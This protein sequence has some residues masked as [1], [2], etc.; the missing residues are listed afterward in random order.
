MSLAESPTWEIHDSTKLQA[1]SR[2]P[3]AYLFEY[4]LGWRPEQPNIHLEFGEAWHRAMET[5]LIHGYSVE[6]QE[7][8]YIR[9]RQHYR[10]FFSEMT[11]DIYYP[12][13][14]GFAKDML[15][16]YCSKYKDDFYHWKVVY[17]EIS[18]RVSI[19]ALRSLAFKV[20]AVVQLT[21][22]P[23]VGKYASPEHKT[24]K[25]MKGAWTR[26]WTNKVQI[27]TYYHVLKCL[28]GSDAYG[29]I[30][31]GAQFQKTDPNFLRLHMI[32][33]IAQMAQWQWEVV[34][35][36]Q[37]IEKDL[38]ICLNWDADKPFLFAFPRNGEACTDYNHPCQYLEYCSVW[39]NPLRF[40][41]NPPQG[42]IVN[43]WNPL[44]RETTHNIDI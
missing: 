26:Q 3:R 7:L 30:I 41:D 22:G 20:D 33:S 37:E 18:G 31:N 4:V 21:D 12:K 24:T 6:A 15:K 1:H 38:E 43:H 13:T 17:T 32:P 39:V 5:L 8:A 27:H 40:A 14:P 35:R 29:I 34:R 19:D 23:H 28:Y 25:T 44:K 9:L 16:K 2:C 42:Y 10:E 36:I 11:D